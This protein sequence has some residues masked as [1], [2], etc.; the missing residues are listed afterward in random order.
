MKHAGRFRCWPARLA[1]AAA[2]F[3][4][5]Q[6]GQAIYI[7]VMYMFLLLGLL[8]LVIN[9]GEKVN[10]KIE[11]QGAADSVATTGAAWY[12][13]G[14][15]VASMCNVG[16]LQLLSTIN[17][18]D[19]LETVAPVAVENIDKLSNEVPVD[20]RLTD[21]NASSPDGNMFLV[22]GNVAA[23]KQVIHQFADIVKGI[24]WPRYLNYN[25]GVLWDCIKLMDGFSH[26]MIRD[27]P[28]AACRE[29]ASIAKENHADCG[30][31][32]PFWPELPVEIGIFQDFK[33]PM[34]LGRMPQRFGGRRISGFGNGVMGY[35]GYG[36]TYLNNRERLLHISGQMG[37]WSY[38][39]EPFVESRPMGLFDLSGF[40]TL[41]NVVSS[42]KFEMLFGDT[43]DQ[44]SLRNWEYDYDK[45]HGQDIRRTWWED[46]SFDA[47]YVDNEESKPFPPP[48]SGA[49][50]A[51][52]WEVDDLYPSTRTYPNPSPWPRV[53]A[54]NTWPSLNDYTR[55][56]Q[57]YEGADPG[58]NVWYR[59]DPRRTAHYPE[60]GIFAPHPP[61]HEDGSRWPYTEA[62]K[63][64]YW[65]V[66]MRRFNGAEL[67]PDT[68]LHRNY[69]PQAGEDPD[70]GPT[71][72]TDL[73]DNLVDNI[74][75]RFTFNGYAYRSGKATNWVQRFINPNPVVDQEGHPELVC[76]AQARVFN[77]ASW[78]LFTQAWRVK[79]MRT[80][81]SYSDN[82]RW[83]EML[84]E[85]NKSVP[86]Q[87]T[88]AA[89]QVGVTLDSQHVKPVRDTVES[90]TAAFV[91]EVTH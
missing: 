45:A 71:F 13:R 64:T 1:G 49:W 83:A 37:P 53:P 30:F 42:M 79:L 67:A 57:P 80:Q 61:L 48:A 23:E 16:E 66:T 2:R 11:M 68:T 26:A 50:T 85:L 6:G 10:H 86:S 12:A 28:R 21:P 19:T 91:K 56:T 25:G 17:L 3:H 24:N 41:F 60:L 90:Y 52:K 73:G 59:V 32:T 78:D 22:A 9:G 74:E 89:A 36:S 43:N 34:R 47:R 75:S 65:H 46:V 18:C 55:A 51:K 31:M 58:R 76:Y 38:W 81:A 84:A 82:N 14:L 15:N 72:L 54:A 29:A 77:P 4:G 62:E 69:M 27:T 5:H 87:A 63:K 88:Q 70:I 35:V 33:D 44:V 8:V 20:L 39:R 7:V 40:G